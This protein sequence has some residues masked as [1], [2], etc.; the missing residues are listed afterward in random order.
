MLLLDKMATIQA[1]ELYSVSEQIR[2]ESN[3]TFVWR[4][5]QGLNSAV[6]QAVATGAAFGHDIRRRIRLL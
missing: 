6:G 2:T 4:P 1:F 5:C 3:C